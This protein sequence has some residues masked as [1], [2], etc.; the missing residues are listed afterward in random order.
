ML[1]LAC[2]IASDGG[3]WSDDANFDQQNLVETYSTSE[4][5]ESSDKLAPHDR[6]QKIAATAD[7]LAGLVEVAD[8]ETVK[9]V[10]PDI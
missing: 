1:Y 5:I 9:E 4:V 6:T 8:T 2:A 3:I 10:E 7:R